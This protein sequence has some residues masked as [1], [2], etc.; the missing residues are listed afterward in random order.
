MNKAVKW[1]LIVILILGVIISAGFLAVKYWP[2]NTNSQANI[3]QRE[4]AAD[5]YV[6]SKDPA[7]DLA[8]DKQ[9]LLKLAT[10]N[11][12]AIDTS[13]VSDV[14]SDLNFLKIKDA[15]NL[16]SNKVS[17]TDG[18]NGFLI[19]MDLD[20]P[21]FS[22]YQT[23]ARSIHYEQGWSQIY[24]AITNTFALLEAKNNTNQIQIRFTRLS[25]E[26]TTVEIK[27]LTK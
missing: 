21:L 16:V 5:A 20:Y 11:F 8:A 13:E 12:L 25:T 2:K 22:A 7:A 18:S 4:Q 24:G 10:L 19:T 26:L 17:Y 23:E 15:T 14:P 6:P 1:V 27:V 3:L 9:K